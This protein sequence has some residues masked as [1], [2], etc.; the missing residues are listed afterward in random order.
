MKE[1]QVQSKRSKSEKDGSSAK[2]MENFIK[3]GVEKLQKRDDI[4]T[5]DL[6]SLKEFFIFVCP[7][8]SENF[9]GNQDFFE[10]HV[11][12]CFTISKNVS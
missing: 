10:Q 11:D 7:H 8:C 3:R 5:E 4:V 6:I 2:I 12:S 9:E 1:T